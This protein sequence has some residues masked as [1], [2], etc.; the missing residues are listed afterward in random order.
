M[1]ARKTRRPSAVIT[2]AV[3]RSSTRPSA[4][5]R[6]RATQSNFGNLK[7]TFSGLLKGQ[8]L[9]RAKIGRRSHG[10]AV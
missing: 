7:L 3:L 6:W 8:L 4:F 1:R 5:R 9:R 10:V 2:T